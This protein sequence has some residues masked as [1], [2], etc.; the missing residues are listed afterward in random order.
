M[1]VFTTKRAAAAALTILALT[2]ATP[3]AWA[4]VNDYEFQLVQDKIK[5]G[6]GAEL[7]V[8]L[9][10]KRSGKPMPDAVILAKRHG[11][12]DRAYRAIAFD[13]G[14]RLPFQSE[15]RNGRRMAAV[16]GR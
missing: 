15:A 5:K 3:L 9:V 16:A 2:T 6:D 7:A 13:R 10:D 11:N 1:I 8:R 14:R 12:D 4:G